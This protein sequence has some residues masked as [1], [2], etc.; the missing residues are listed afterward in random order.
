M[1]E[2]LNLTYVFDSSDANLRHQ[3]K[4]K[5]LKSAVRMCVSDKARLIIKRSQSCYCPE[6]KNHAPNSDIC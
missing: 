5:G 6:T 3:N 2:T 1:N 4:T